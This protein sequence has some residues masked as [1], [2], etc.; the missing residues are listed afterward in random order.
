MGIRTLYMCEPSWSDDR[1][2]TSS[3]ILIRDILTKSTIL[4]PANSDPSQRPS[5]DVRQNLLQA[6]LSSLRRRTSRS[7][8]E[9]RRRHPPRNTWSQ[10]CVDVG[11]SSTL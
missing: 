10:S 4:R 1:S 2:H 7:A 8:R 11:G 9:G 6:H 3:D 5:H